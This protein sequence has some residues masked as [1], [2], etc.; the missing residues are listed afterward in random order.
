MILMCGFDES[1]GTRGLQ[2]ICGILN[3]KNLWFPQMFL[4]ERLSGTMHLAIFEP[5]P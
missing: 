2:K 1:D 5:K 4:G 3:T